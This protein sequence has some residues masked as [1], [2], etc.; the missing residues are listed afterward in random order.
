MNKIIKIEEF[1]S[2]TKREIL[3]KSK[4]AKTTF[5]KEDLNGRSIELYKMVTAKLGGSNIYYP[6]VLIKSF[7]DDIIINPYQE[8]IMSMS[9]A[10][11]ANNENKEFNKEINNI[12]LQI[13]NNTSGLVPF[14]ETCS[15]NPKNGGSSIC[16]C[17]MSHK[18]VDRN[19]TFT[20]TS[21]T[22]SNTDLNFDG[23]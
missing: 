23:K 16:G 18:M 11:N 10:L 3:L 2:I 8:R 20:T 14:Y 1:K 12:N 17:T 22:T 5:K 19:T 4:N 6:N 9:N 7:H 13:Q 21:T 15:C